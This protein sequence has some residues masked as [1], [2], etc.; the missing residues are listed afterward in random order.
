MEE[1]WKPISNYE[2]IYEVSNLGRFRK[3]TPKGL[4]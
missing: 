1:I 3:I 4:F 2:K